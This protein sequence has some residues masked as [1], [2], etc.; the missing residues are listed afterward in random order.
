[1]T[2]EEMA[3][4]AV[5]LEITMPASTAQTPQQPPV[6]RWKLAARR[7]DLEMEDLRALH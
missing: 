6:S 1:M 7:P 3:A 5:A 2:E 4:L